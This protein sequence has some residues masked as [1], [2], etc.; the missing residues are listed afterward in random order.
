MKVAHSTR[1]VSANTKPHKLC[2]GD[3]EMGT[4]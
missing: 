1:R 2:W 3:R 4:A